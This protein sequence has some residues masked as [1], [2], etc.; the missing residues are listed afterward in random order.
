MAYVITPNL[1]EAEFLSKIRISNK[2]DMT[3][4]TALEIF[5]LGASNVIIKGGHDTNKDTKVMDLLFRDKNIEPQQ[6]VHE[7]L[8][9]DETH[10]TGCNFR[11]LSLPF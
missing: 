8:K 9:V 1:K 3:R 5:K 7:R 4:V 11:L 10:G 2:Y 6:I